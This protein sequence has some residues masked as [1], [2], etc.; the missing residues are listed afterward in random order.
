MKNQNCKKK[1]SK[2]LTKISYKCL[3]FRDIFSQP[4]K[5]ANGSFCNDSTLVL[6]AGL[7]VAETLLLLVKLLMGLGNVNKLSNAERSGFLLGAEFAE[8]AGRFNAF[9][10]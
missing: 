8:F 7:E 9:T 3:F 6:A 4:N 2:R 10:F 5:S 1:C